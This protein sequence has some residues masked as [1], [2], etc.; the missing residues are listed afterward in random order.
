M[1]AP[2]S[3]TYAET[4]GG[5]ICWP[6]NGTLTMQNVVTVPRVGQLDLL[7]GRHAVGRA[8][9]ARRDVD[10]LAGRAALAED[11]ALGEAAEERRLLGRRG[12]EVVE[13]DR[14]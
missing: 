4:Y 11:P 14:A 10:L 2:S 7:G 13:L 8:G 6:R 9:A 3:R 5:V 12:V 1:S